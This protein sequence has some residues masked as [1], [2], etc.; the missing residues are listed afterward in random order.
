MRNTLLPYFLNG[1]ARREQQQ[2]PHTALQ[3]AKGEMPSLA[4]SR[5]GPGATASKKRR[6][7]S[8]GREWMTTN[9]RS[10]MEKVIKTSLLDT[11]A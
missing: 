8:E 6:K 10:Q 11:E 7:A 4:S 5:S 2:R 1:P 3:R 9:D